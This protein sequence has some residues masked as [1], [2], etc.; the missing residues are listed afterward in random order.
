MDA[1]I[2]VPID[3]RIIN[4][5][6]SIEE[7][8][9]M[10]DNNDEEEEDESTQE[11]DEID[12][13][14]KTPPSNSVLIVDDENEPNTAEAFRELEYMLNSRRYNYLSPR[15][16]EDIAN[17]AEDINVRV[18]SLHE[19]WEYEEAENSSTTSSNSNSSSNS[20]VKNR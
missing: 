20:I 17:E 3:E 10:E 12:E 2:P 5:N 6:K 16:A 14:P 15:T 1:T 4:Y 9:K 19:E 18:P 13:L 8:K 11:D 7:E